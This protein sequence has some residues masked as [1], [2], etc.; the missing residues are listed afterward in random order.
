MAACCAP[1]N[2]VGELLGLLHAV[3]DHQHVRHL[4]IE[5]DSI[6]AMNTYSAWMDAHAARGWTTQAKK[7][8]SNREII[9]QLIAVRDARRAAGQPPV[10]LVKVKGHAGGRYPLNDAADIQATTASARARNRDLGPWSGT[11]MA[12]TGVRR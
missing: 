6:Y 1:P 12:I 7:P 10:K 9:E 5:I 3:R 4:T 2:Q 8:T 11:G